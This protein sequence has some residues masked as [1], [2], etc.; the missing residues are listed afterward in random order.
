MGKV[1]YGPTEAEIKNLVFRRSI[2]VSADIKKGE[3]FTNE[4]LRGVRPGDG[5]PPWL[6]N[7]VL[8]HVSKYNYKAGTALSIQKLF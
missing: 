7:H 6:L 5:A 2:Y 4:N 3:I 8:G 1:S